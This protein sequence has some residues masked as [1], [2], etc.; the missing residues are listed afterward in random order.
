MATG[1]VP[2]TANSP[3]TAKGDL[4][5][6]ST[7]PARLAVGNNGESLV[8]DSAATTGLRYQSNFAAGKNAIINGAFNVWQRGTS[9]SLTN[10][11][12]VYTADR[13]A[14]KC[15]FTA[16]TSSVTQQ[17]FTPGTAPVAGY[18]GQYFARLTCGSTSTY[19]LFT[20]KIEDVRTFAGQTITISLWAKA[21][22][23]VT[24]SVTPVQNFGS[25]GSSPVNG[26]TGNA[27]LT[28]S[29]V[30][31]SFTQTLASIS[32]KTVGT[33]S[34]VQVYTEFANNMNSATIDIW[35]VQ[36]EAS[37]TA[38]A[39]Q[40]ATGTL[41]G[42]LAAC[43]RYYYR[44]TAAAIGERLGI[45]YAGTTTVANIAYPLPVSMRVTPTAI[46]TTGTAADYSIAQASGNT[47]CSTTPAF[48]I[49]NT[50]QILFQASVA[51]GLTAG[52]A[53]GMR[54]AAANAYVG[55][56]AEL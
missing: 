49:A 46:E 45:G 18:E 7:A 15:N 52:Q 40:T 30:R 42:E 3:L 8:A 5:G 25:G 20:Q 6:Y 36:V 12:E 39:F 11:V 51:S 4:F 34:F 1:R 48:G 21:S 35:G 53:I 14:A 31:Y 24:L 28:T 17:T 2:T 33:S 22:A 23:A 9:I 37:N 26:S 10:G 13:F 32:G 55:V 16:G 27:T 19:G 56:T 41:Q 54:F 43:Q 29:W 47:V 38:T 44:V 50:W